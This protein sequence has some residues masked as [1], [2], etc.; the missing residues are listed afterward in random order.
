MSDPADGSPV[1]PFMDK[2]IGSKGNCV[3]KQLHHSSQQ[4]FMMGAEI[5]PERE[6]HSM[7][8]QLN[9]QENFTAFSY[10]QIYK[11]K[12]SSKVSFGTSESEH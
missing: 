4:M 11:V 7:L 10:I 6:I 12:S 8:M 1:G 5:V 9:A 3:Y 2:D